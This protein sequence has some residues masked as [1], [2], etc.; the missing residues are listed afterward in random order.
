MKTNAVLIFDLAKC[1]VFSIDFRSSLEL[2]AFCA[3]I[4]S[5]QNHPTTVGRLALWLFPVV[6]AL[7]SC[8][9]RL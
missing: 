8:S 4:L 2:S 1:P 6:A 7:M 3:A 9:I 5:V